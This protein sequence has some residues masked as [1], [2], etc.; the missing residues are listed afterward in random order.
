[1]AAEDNVEKFLCVELFTRN[2]WYRKPRT[3]RRHLWSITIL[4]EDG[5]QIRGGAMKQTQTIE[6][7]NSATKN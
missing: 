4:F 2:E 7:I 1:M 3:E 5:L 6:V